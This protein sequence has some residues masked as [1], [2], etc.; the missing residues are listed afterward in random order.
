MLPTQSPV[1]F[2]VLSA[3]RNPELSYHS[4]RARPV[5]TPFYLASLW[6]LPNSDSKKEKY[7]LKVEHEKDKCQLQDGKMGVK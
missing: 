6:S 4:G 7:H 1:R 2:L 5:D 3:V